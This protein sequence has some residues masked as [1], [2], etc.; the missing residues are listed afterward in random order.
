MLDT[1]RVLEA[2]LGVVSYSAEG[3]PFGDGVGQV[4]LFWG[5]HLGSIREQAL[6]AWDCDVYLAVFYH[7][8]G[9]ALIWNSAK[10]QLQHL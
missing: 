7:E 8:G 4:M 3:Y 1:V 6:I 5:S 2:I 10:R 9:V